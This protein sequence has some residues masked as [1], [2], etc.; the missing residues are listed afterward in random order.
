MDFWLT[1]QAAFIASIQNP[2]SILTP[3]LQVIT[4]LGNETFF[5][6]IMPVSYWCV[7][8]TLGIRVGIVLLFSEGLTSAFKML[9]HQPRPFWIDPSIKALAEEKTFGLPSGHAQNAVWGLLA[10]SLNKRWSWI[11]AIVLIVLIGISRIFLGMHFITDVIAGWLIGILFLM[12]FLRLEK[13][14]MTWFKRQNPLGQA[15]ILIGITAVFILINLA[16]YASVG[17]WQV[18][19]IWIQNALLS[20]NQ[21]IDPY[22]L[23]DLMSK[24]GV[25]L[26]LIGGAAWIMQ[27]QGFNAWGTPIQKILRYLIGVAGV[28]LIYYV[29]STIFPKDETLVGF[30]FRFIRYGLIGIWITVGAPLTFMSLKLAKR[31]TE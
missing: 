1:A 14:A 24:S 30:T 28:F 26:G 11:V 8:A 6:L 10:A 23:A 4:Q 21:S 20:S 17:S 27:K 22:S 9:F 13:P 25:F 29:L 5:L 3:I 7:D 16:A 31:Q 19:E 15:G 2:G 12:A 18:P